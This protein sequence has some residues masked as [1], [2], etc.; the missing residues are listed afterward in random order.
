MYKA[1]GLV[2]W[3]KEGYKEEREE[4]RDKGMGKE[5]NFKI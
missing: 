3:G 5:E 2:E 1:L 4:W